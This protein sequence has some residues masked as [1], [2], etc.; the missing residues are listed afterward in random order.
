MMAGSNFDGKHPSTIAKPIDILPVNGM[1]KFGIARSVGWPLVVR[2][3]ICVITFAS[4]AIVFW[5]AT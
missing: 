2:P 1:P 3:R 4:I 5:D